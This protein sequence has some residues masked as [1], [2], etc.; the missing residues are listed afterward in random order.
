MDKRKVYPKPK[1]N[2][3][4]DWSDGCLVTYPVSYDYNGGIVIDGEW[5]KGFEVPAPHIPEGYELQGIGVGLQLNAHPP[6]ATG[7]LKK[8]VPNAPKPDLTGGWVR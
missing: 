1:L 2:R 6:Y 7:Y 4:E 3:T 8:V 5:Y